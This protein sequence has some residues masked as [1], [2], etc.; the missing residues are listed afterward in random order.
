[1][2]CI[3]LQDDEHDAAPE[4]DD[5]WAICPAGDAADVGDPFQAAWLIAGLEHQVWLRGLFGNCSSI[6]SALNRPFPV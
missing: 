6:A 4:G 3:G 5:S 1:M 2:R